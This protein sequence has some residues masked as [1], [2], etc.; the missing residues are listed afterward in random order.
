MKRSRRR[1]VEGLAR[2]DRPERWSRPD[3]ANAGARGR[4]LA[5]AIERNELLLRYQPIVDLRS[6]ECRRVEALLRWRTPHGSVPP[7]Q[8]VDIAVATGQTAALSLW[9]IGA[10]ARQWAAWREVGLGLQGLFVGALCGSILA[11]LRL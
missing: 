9:V 5:R 10:A 11:L 1:V 7:A 3:A 4:E 6:G 8:V 2:A